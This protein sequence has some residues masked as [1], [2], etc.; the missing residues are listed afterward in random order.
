MAKDLTKLRSQKPTWLALDDKVKGT[1][2]PSQDASVAS[3]GTVSHTVEGAANRPHAQLWGLLQLLCDIVEVEH[4][5]GGSHDEA[6]MGFSLW[7]KDRPELNDITAWTVSGT[8]SEYY[9]SGATISY[10]PSKVYANDVLLTEGTVGA[11]TNGQWAF[12]NNDTLANDTIYVKLT[13]GNPASQA[14]G[15][16]QY[17]KYYRLTSEISTVIDYVNTYLK[18][19]VDTNITNIGTNITNIST[20]A[21]SISTIN[22]FLSA[23]HWRQSVKSILSTPPVSPTTGDRHLIGLSATGVWN[24]HDNKITEWNGSTWDFYTPQANWNVMVTNVD[25]EYTYDGDTSLWKLV[26]TNLSNWLLKT[27]AYTAS[28]NDPIMASTTGG[29]WN[30]TLPLNPNSG[31]TVLVMDVDSTFAT[32]NLT[33]LRNSEKINGASENCVLNYDPE[34]VI[35]FTYKNSTLGWSVQ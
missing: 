21:S 20:N 26:P 15:Y 16:M 14:A 2:T 32:N 22:S 33:V 1:A 6:T 10:K 13:V 17:K 4:A 11:L 31:D 7:A 35:Y 19:L 24:T 30:L 28:A 25:R 3:D 34:R 9:Y 27:S 23:I 5:V 8:N 29:A 12:A 18:A